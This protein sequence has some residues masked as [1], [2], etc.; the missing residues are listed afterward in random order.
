MGKFTNRI[1]DGLKTV[2]KANYS[3]WQLQSYMTGPEW[4]NVEMAKEFAEYLEDGKSLFWFPYFRQIR[5]LWRV[6]GKSYTAARKYNSRSEIWFKTDYMF[7]DLFVAF[8]TTLELAPKG[9]LSLIV[10]RFVDKEHNSDFQEY[11]ADYF[12][13]YAKRLKTEPFYDHPYHQERKELRKAY[14]ESEDKTIIDRISYYLIS[15]DMF[16]RKWISKPLH[17]WFHQETNLI[18]ATTDIIVKHRVPNESNRE[19]AKQIFKEKL[20]A[21]NADATIVEEADQKV[22]TR[23]KD[24][25]S[26]TW[27]YARLRA[28]RYGAFQATLTSLAD[29]HIY[30]RKSAGHDQVQVKVMID[31]DNKEEL[32]DTKAQI[33]K[34][35]HADY[36]YSYVDRIHKNREICMFDVPV[37]NLHKTVERFNECPNATVKFIHHF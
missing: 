33:K 37:K 30:L 12:K 4:R 20:A 17:Y 16:A 15:I 32:N 2:D 6:V 24:G 9:L 28:P 19:K 1:D 10:R 5:D 29:Q 14:K 34:V 31:A 18:P 11:L 3:R 36:L 7:M 8:F 22:R 23:R 21:S 25:H 35:K 27:V 13:R 26:S